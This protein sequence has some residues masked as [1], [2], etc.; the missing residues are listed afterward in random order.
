MMF[1]RRTHIVQVHFPRNGP[2]S[3][4]VNFAAVNRSEWWLLIV[5]CSRQPN[6]RTKSPD[7]MYRHCRTVEN[8]GFPVEITHINL[9]LIVSRR[10]SASERRDDEQI[11]FIWLT[12]LAQPR[13]TLFVIRIRLPYV[14]SL[15]SPRVRRLN[16]LCLIVWMHKSRANYT[17]FDADNGGHCTNL[18][19]RLISF[20]FERSKNRN[21]RWEKDRRDWSLG[22]FRS[23]DCF[24]QQQWRNLWFFANT[25]HLHDGGRRTFTTWN[26]SFN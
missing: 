23:L 9:N 6:S 25:S 12:W 19:E 15:I 3:V 10:F 21:R 2:A 4:F 1:G 13:F 14:G 8:N 24:T 17:I 18:F 22:P 16:G 26:H 11:W 7:T 20:G 5:G